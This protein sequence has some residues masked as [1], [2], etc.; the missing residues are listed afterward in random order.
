MSFCIR[1]ILAE[2]TLWSLHCVPGNLL[3]WDL[4]ELSPLNFTDNLWSL[5]H[6]YFLFY[7]YVCCMFSHIW[8]FMTPWTIA[9]KTPLSME[10][11]R[12]KYWH[13]LPFPSPG[14]LPDP[15][16]KPTSL[17][18]PALAGRFF[19]TEPPGKP[20]FSFYRKLLLRAITEDHLARKLQVSY[21]PN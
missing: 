6:N 21:S 13:G 19:T 1:V 15:G 16:I 4:H 18:P 20:P 17:A 12:Q 5:Y 10:F 14:D 9:C 7:V 2:K 11:S 8:I 3:S